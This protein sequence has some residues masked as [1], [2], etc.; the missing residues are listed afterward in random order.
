MIFAQ[1]LPKAVARSSTSY[2]EMSRS[3]LLGNLSCLVP[4]QLTQPK[5]RRRR[6]Q[7]YKRWE[8]LRSMELW[9]ID[10]MGNVRRTN[11]IPVSV[12]Q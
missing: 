7:D 1:L 8:R 6:S 9:Q 11:G 10:V 2:A 3:F 4:H 12:S 5:P